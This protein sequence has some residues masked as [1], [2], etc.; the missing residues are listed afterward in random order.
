M[1][2]TIIKKK[3]AKYKSFDFL[4]CL[5]MSSRLH[6]CRFQCKPDVKGIGVCGREAP[7]SNW[8]EAAWKKWNHIYA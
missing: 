7:H 2:K 3:Y 5:M 6:V 8:S 4:G 1:I